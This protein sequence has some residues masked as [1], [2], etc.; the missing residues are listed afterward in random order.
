[1]TGLPTSQVADWLTHKPTPVC[2]LV[3]PAGS[4]KTLAALAACASIDRAL[5]APLSA[6]SPDRCLQQ[7]FKHT[8][9]AGL[10]AAITAAG[11][12]L[13]VLDALD[14]VQYRI[15]GEHGAS[16]FDS[17][18]RH[19]LS[20]VLRGA[21]PAMGVLVTSRLPPPQ[22]LRS[23][24]VT[25]IELTPTPSTESSRSVG[26][27]TAVLELIASSRKATSGWL[28]GLLTGERQ[29]QPSLTTPRGLRAILDQA[30]T[31]GVVHG[32][33][34]RFLPGEAGSY[35]SRNTSPTSAG[36]GASSTG[37]WF[38]MT[39]AA[40]ARY[41]PPER[42]GRIHRAVADLLESDTLSLYVQLAAETDP[43][44][45]H[46]LEERAIIHRLDA[47]DI[48]GAVSG[49]WQRLGNYSQLRN[50]RALHVGVRVCCTLN[51][52][53]LPSDVDERLKSSAGA[54]A[55]MNDWGVHAISLGDA[56][57][58]TDAALSAYKLI[59]ED[60]PPTDASMLACHAADGLLLRAR[61]PEAMEWAERAREHARVGARL[62]EGMPT[63]E[64]MSGYDDAFYA[65]M[66]IAAASRDAATAARVLDELMDVHSRAREKLAE[67]NRSAVVPLAGPAGEVEA[68][69]LVDGKAA[70]LAASLAGQPADAVRILSSALAG[71]SPEGRRS[72]RGLTML[73]L[74]LR[75]QLAAGDYAEAS[76]SI[77]DV[78]RLADDLDDARA[79][80]ELTSMAAR[81]ALKDTRLHDGLALVDDAL[82][83][84]S[85]F[86]LELDRSMLLE[87]RAEAL[88]A[89]G[90]TDESRVA[91]ES[92]RV[93]TPAP[94]AKPFG[95]PRRSRPRDP[96]ATAVPAEERRRQLHAAAIAVIDAYQT[97]G[98][99]FA[100]YFRKYA[101]TVSHGPMEFGPQLTENALR[102]A[103]P[104]GA[105]VLTVQS[106]EDD[107]LD[108]SGTGSSFNRAA[109]A[110]FL[111][112]ADWQQLVASLIPFADLIVSEAYWL[113]PGVRFELEVAIQTKR[114]DRTVVLL[115]PLKTYL[116][117]IDSDPV[118]QAFPRAVWMDQFHT[119][120]LIESPVVSDLVDRMK[121][122]AALPDA[123]RQRLVE[124]AARDKAHPIDLLPIA[125]HY[126]IDARWQSM[127]QNEDDRI[128]YYGFWELFRAASIRG[129][130][131]QNGDDSFTNRS[132]LSSVYVEMSA[133]MLDHER[134]GDKIVLVGDLTFA[135]K[136]AQSACALIRD[137]DGPV[138]LDYFRPLAEKQ[139]QQVREVRAAVESDPGR[140]VLR[141][142]Y[143]PFVVHS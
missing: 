30:V 15:P 5:L 7:A 126:E 125:R 111:D 107:A 53:R 131:M 73:V 76:K 98:L 96:V 90:R 37:E 86:G 3:G 42:A 54:I 84:A 32:V 28:L 122:I 34:L 10:F 142:R 136:C 83:L 121:R 13:L 80:C 99:P 9:T 143:G 134:D 108:Y 39:D 55:V 67:F 112:D 85:D 17:R 44:L 66:R 139:L 58:A 31:D 70:A 113:S 69:Q 140:F 26:D 14:V 94:P 82:C 132:S 118:I 59:S 114:W 65:I 46:D 71:W 81:I 63:Q 87:L 116:A 100:L 128:R 62:A 64:V 104:A 23:G 77:A 106:H 33:D 1:M 36:S 135:E 97:H 115:P 21:W 127:R 123:E 22:E 61:L 50:E 57:L 48:D 72:P 105:Q 51:A 138:A 16:I 56:A 12:K 2:W 110:L 20:S 103:M 68:D 27:A 6:A 29:E 89:L 95:A 38:Q 130:L 18:L 35:E 92:I 79:R 60:T 8:T 101:L 4:G 119:Q 93:S 52:H 120:P 124:P 133:I 40:R 19:L 49:Y 43:E 141:P 117:V 88:L 41:L 11:T 129:H 102:D 24:G 45:R 47:G 75:A 91:I 74:L 109:P 78:M 137:D 25:V